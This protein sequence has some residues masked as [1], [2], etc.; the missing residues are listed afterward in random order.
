MRDPRAEL[1]INSGELR[2]S[3]QVQQQTNAPDGTT[4]AP[5][6]A[7]VPVLTT[8]AKISTARSSEVF[9]AAQFSAQ[10]SHV[11]KIRWPGAAVTLAGGMQVVFGSRVFKLQ[12]VEN[13]LERNRVV[14]L[15]C[16][17]IN[18]VQA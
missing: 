15:H 1:I 7:W 9:Q 17:E 6:Q 13:V 2:H 8:M 18:G 12:T 16:L 14:L 5:S 3:I 4:G 11:I 10:V